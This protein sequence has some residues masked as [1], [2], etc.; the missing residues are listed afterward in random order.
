MQRVKLYILLLIT[1]ILCTNCS[2][3][4]VAHKIQNGVKIEAFENIEGSLSGGWVLTL[5]IKNDT[6]YKP[7]LQSAE[8]DIFM[9]GVQTIHASLRSPITLP[10]NEV[11]SIA[12]PLEVSIKNPLKAFALIMQLSDRNFNGIELSLDSTVEV[13]GVKRDFFID[14]TPV[15]K[16]LTKLGYT[17]Q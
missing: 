14:K 16:I 11:A 9:S 15:N 4:K 6:G 7:T 12:I 2:P 3:K 17:A 8:A 10:K 13:M 5:R 1:A